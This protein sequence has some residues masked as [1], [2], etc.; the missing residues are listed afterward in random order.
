MRALTHLRVDERAGLPR[1]STSNYFRTRAALLQGIVEH[2]VTRE[3]PAVDSALAPKSIDELID[4]LGRLFEFMTGPNRVMTAARLTLLMEASHDAELRSALAQG[5]QVMERTVLP[6][7]VALGAP[8]PLL[9]TQALAACFEGLFLHQIA[10]HAD[11]APRPVLDLVIR[12]AL[13][14]H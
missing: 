7:L 5:R 2:M 14:R 9:A 12:A 1:G 3:L 10:R 8:D 4:A 13:Q 6:T 11:I